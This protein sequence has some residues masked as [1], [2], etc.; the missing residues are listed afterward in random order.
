MNLLRRALGWSRDTALGCYAAPLRGGEQVPWGKAT[1]VACIPTLSRCA[2]ALRENGTSGPA[3][4]YPR[5][6]WIATALL[7]AACT[8]HAAGTLTFC[9]DAAPEGFDVVQYETVPTEDAAG[10]PLYDKLMQ[11]KPG[12]TELVPGLAQRWEVDSAGTTYTFHLRKGVKFHATPWFT[13]TRE[14][15]ADDVL[16]SLQRLH[17]PRHPAHGAARN[18]YPYWS[19][20]GMNGLVKSIAKAGPM[21][22]RIELTRPEAAFVANMA[23]SSLASV[24]SAEYAAQLQK[25]GKLEQLNTQPIGTGPF[26]FKSYQKDATIRYAA[27]TA[28]WG[29]APKVAQLVFAITPDPAVRLQRL[30]AGECMV[31]LLLGD[32]VPALQG[33]ARLS[34]LMNRPLSTT[35]IAPNARHG[36]LGDKRLREALSLAIDRQAFVQAVYG[37][38]AEPAGSF[39]PPRIWSHDASIRNVRDPQRARALVKASGYDGRELQLFATARDGGVQ[40]GVAL[41]QADWAAIGVKVRVQLMEL[42]E[43]YRRTGKGE[44]DL[45]L[46]SWFSDNGDPDNFLTPNLSC[47]AVQG[48]GNKAQW[49]DKAFDDLLS[50]ARATPDVAKRTA[51]YRQAQA[52]LHAETG[53]IPV[54]HKLSPHGVSKRVQGY[55]ATPFGSSDFRMAEVVDHP[56]SAFGAPP[57]GGVASGPAEP[58]PRRPWARLVHATR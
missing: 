14:L 9:S 50:A 7:A 45:A 10:L 52:R 46:L 5:R 34:V 57:Q 41:L 56:R 49:C 19:G 43:L 4:L 42:G 26:V 25:A 32:Q 51:L 16:W 8:A 40:R 36:A 18:G 21:A 53:L 31:G 35:Y 30:R 15:N 11:F 28:Y 58:D 47:A 27:N 13:P 2:M 39:L 6:P 12:S 20:M 24:Y 1:A 3:K 54:A 55:I 37:G 29:G 22:V 17:D 38:H 23:M 48:G 44:H 33:D